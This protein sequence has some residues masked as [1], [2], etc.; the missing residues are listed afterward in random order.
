MW[1]RFRAIE[2]SAF[3]ARAQMDDGAVLQFKVGLGVTL[4]VTMG[5]VVLGRLKPRLGQNIARDLALAAR[6]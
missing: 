4:A 2:H 5:I 3:S 1:S 6:A